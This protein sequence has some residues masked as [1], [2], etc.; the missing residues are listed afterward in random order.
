M[1]MKLCVCVMRD[2]AAQAFGVPQF[3]VSKGTAV[4]AFGDEVNRQDP[5]NAFFSH[6]EDFE[7][8]FMGTFDDQSAGFDLLAE[9]ELLARGQ[10]LKR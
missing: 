9:P 5:Q 10:D 7:L 1:A 6:P 2:S 8:Y 4:R 3:Q